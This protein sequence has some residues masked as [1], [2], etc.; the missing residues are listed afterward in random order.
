MSRKNL[1]TLGLRLERATECI[2]LAANAGDAMRQSL[3]RPNRVR[4]DSTQVTAFYRVPCGSWN[5]TA[6][7]QFVVNPAYNRDRGPVSVFG[8]RVHTQF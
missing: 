1:P 4:H 5:I 3:L 8:L 6:D 7:Y 2:D